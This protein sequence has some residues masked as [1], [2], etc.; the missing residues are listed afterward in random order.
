MA[1]V[2]KQRGIQMFQQRGVQFAVILMVLL[3]LF[4]QSMF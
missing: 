4:V 3:L 1:A 2:K